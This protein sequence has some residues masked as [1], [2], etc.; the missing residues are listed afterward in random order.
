MKAQ[1]PGEVC[2]VEGEYMPARR[3]VRVAQSSR[4]HYENMRFETPS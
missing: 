3:D 2:T 1:R 4:S